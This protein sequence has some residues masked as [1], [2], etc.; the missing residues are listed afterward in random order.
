MLRSGHVRQSRRSL[1]IQEQLHQEQLHQLDSG[2]IGTV[3]LC[4]VAPP[5]GWPENEEWSVD[6]TKPR[7]KTSPG[8]FSDEVHGAPDQSG[9]CASDLAAASSVAIEQVRCLVQ[10]SLS[11][12]SHQGGFDSTYVYLPKIMKNW[13]LAK[14]SRDPLSD[15]C[16]ACSPA[17]L[18]DL[19]ALACK[20]RC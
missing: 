1:Q 5:H 3:P 15:A 16:Q 11:S 2:L 7:G 12:P 6:R 17:S 19:A 20:C 14:K 10:Y 9:F 13:K 4:Q 18:R 8:C